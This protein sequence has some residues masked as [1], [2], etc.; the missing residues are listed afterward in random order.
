MFPVVLHE[1]SSSECVFKVLKE[2]RTLS[3]DW[4][5]GELFITIISGSEQV[6]IDG[7]LMKRGENQ[8][9]I[10]NY[11]TGEI[12]FTSF[13]PIYSQNFINVSYNYTNRNYTRFLITGNIKHQREKLKAGFSWFM[14]NDNKNAPL[15]LNLVMK[16]SKHWLMQETIRIRCIRRLV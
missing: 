10:I 15:S 6:Y 14:E 1:V 8:D 2:I 11:N 16:T 13:R 5:N 4:K 9:Y 12:T 3:I 7:I